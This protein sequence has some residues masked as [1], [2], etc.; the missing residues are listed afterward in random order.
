M[1]TANPAMS[2]AVYRREGRVDTSTKMMTLQG[3]VGE[4]ARAA[5]PS[6]PRRKGHHPG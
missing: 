6:A 5:R 3:A 2:E 1:A 4:Q